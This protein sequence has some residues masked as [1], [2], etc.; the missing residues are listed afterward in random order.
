MEVPAV[1]EAEAIGTAAGLINR[2]TAVN[3]S[4][5]GYTTFMARG[6]SLNSAETTPAVNGAIA[7]TYE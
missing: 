5:T 7:W 6:A 3:T 2:T 1:G 4:D